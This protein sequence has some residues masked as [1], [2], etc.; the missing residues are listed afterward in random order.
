VAYVGNISFEADDKALAELF[1]DFEVTK[2]RL[3]TDP[4]TGASKGFAHVHFKDDEALEA[5]MAMDGA[6]LCGRAIKMG[7][8]QP[9]KGG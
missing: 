3:H 5:A 8:A 1:Q 6:S 4:S 7:Y 9:R 2:V